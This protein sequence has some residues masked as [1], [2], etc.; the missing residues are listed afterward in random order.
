[1]KKENDEDPPDGKIAIISSSESFKDDISKAFEKDIMPKSY[2]DTGKIM[3]F[4]DAKEFEE[5]VRDI[6]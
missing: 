1:M 4:K 6:N 3:W 2:K 5:H